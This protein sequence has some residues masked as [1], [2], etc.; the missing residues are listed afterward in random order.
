MLLHSF[1]AAALALRCADA[2]LFSGV[3]SDGAVL[4]RAPARA[5]LFGVLAAPSGSTAHVTLNISDSES[6]YSGSFGADVAADGTWKVLLSP[7]P[8]FGNYTVAAACDVGC[9]SPADTAV[10][11]LADLTFGDCFYTT[12][13]SNMWLPLK[14]TFDRNASLAALLAG[15]YSTLRFFNL[16]AATSTSPR[17]VVNA[18]RGPGPNDGYWR[19]AS[20][21]AADIV[22]PSTGESAFVSF[23]STAW[24]FG[25]ALTDLMQANGSAVP[26]GLIHTAVGGTMVEQWAPFDAQLGCVNATC[27]CTSPACN[28]LQ[29]LNPANCTG[30]GQL[31]NALVAPFVNVTV[32]GWLW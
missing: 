27:L 12:G 15:K 23:S 30:N 31:F 3:F 24:Y 21:A 22:D 7:R 9:T 8:A 25:Q 2:G 19:H 20:A 29:P 4:Q 26:I 6:G 5:A 11:A 10:S 16:P 32:F 1:I 18:S 28:R 13:Q 17:F 14:N